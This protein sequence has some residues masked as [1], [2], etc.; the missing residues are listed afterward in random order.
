MKYNVPGDLLWA[1]KCPSMAISA[2]EDSLNSYVEVGFKGQAKGMKV[3]EGT[4]RVI[5]GRD[6]GSAVWRH[7]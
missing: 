7:P 2:S 1:I 5:Q 3:H 6:D 4:L